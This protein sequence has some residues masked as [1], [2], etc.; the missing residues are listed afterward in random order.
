MK[1]VNVTE[2]RAVITGLNEGDA[3]ALIDPDAAAQR[4]KASSGP[5]PASSAPAK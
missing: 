2:S 3:I 5:L 4:S 1:V